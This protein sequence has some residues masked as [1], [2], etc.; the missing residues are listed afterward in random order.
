MREYVTVNSRRFGFSDGV[1]GSG[2]PERQVF[3][4]VN[5]QFALGK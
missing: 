4:G 5:F 2:H 3:V 1:H